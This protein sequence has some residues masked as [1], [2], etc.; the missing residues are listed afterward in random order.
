MSNRKRRGRGEGSVSYF[1]PRKCYR[2]RIWLAGQR[3]QVYGQ[4]EAEVRDKLHKLE[5]KAAAG[6][7]FDA[8]KLTTGDYLQRW[9]DTTVPTSTT[10]STAIRYRQTVE[11]HIIPHIGGVTLSKLTALHV[12]TLYAKVTAA[13]RSGKV[14]A[15][16]LVNALNCAARQKLIPWNPCAGAKRPR[17]PRTEIGILDHAQV[18][19]LLQHA[20]GNRLEALFITALH[21]GLRKG[22]LL[23][24]HW[25]DIDFNANTISVRRSLAD[26]KAGLALKEPKSIRSRRTLP[27]SNAVLDALNAHRRAMLT[28]GQDVTAGPVYVTKNGTFITQANL[29]HKVWEPL[30]TRAGLSCR[31]H[32]LRHTHASH[33]L[34]AKVAIQEVSRRLGHYDEGFTLRTYAHLLPSSAEELRRQL[35]TLYA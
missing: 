21:T 1:E 19:A 9:L 11:L 20:A 16:V 17:R 12:E 3:H 29:H 22:E 32:D 26:T 35:E 13:G 15:E 7:N 18:K 30:L 23:G 24:L 34:H 33:L 27:V 5:L 8:D 6:H 2:G 10:K 31:F 14:V 25:P 4:T 28:E